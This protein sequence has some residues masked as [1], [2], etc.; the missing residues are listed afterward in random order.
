MMIWNMVTQT[1]MSSPS[2]YVEINLGD[3]GLTKLRVLTS[4]GGFKIS[5]VAILRV[6]PL[7]RDPDHYHNP[8]DIPELLAV[9]V[10]AASR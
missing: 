4:Q 7:I 5:C 8:A 1:K 10:L 2:L 6:L 3:S 9:T